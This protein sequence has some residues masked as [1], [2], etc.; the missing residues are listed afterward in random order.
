MSDKKKYDRLYSAMYRLKHPEWKKESNKKCN[1]KNLNYQKEY[2]KVWVEKNIE[3]RREIARSYEERMSK[4]P[5]HRIDR[6]FGTII[7]KVLKGNKK[8]RSW[9][10]LVGYS[11]EEL[12]KHIERQFDKKMN[13]NNYGTYWEVDHIKPKSLFNYSSYEDIE[14]ERCWA[15]GNLRPLERTENRRKSNKYVLI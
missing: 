7:C 6:N 15:L 2:N 11:F 3:R 1:A 4:S 10:Q 13:W 8:R 9:K 12:V 5:K 14:F